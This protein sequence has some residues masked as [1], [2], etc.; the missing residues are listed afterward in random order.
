[1]AGSMNPSADPTLLGP[2]PGPGQLALFD[3]PDAPP[4]S[5]HEHFHHRDDEAYYRTHRDQGKPRFSLVPGI[6]VEQAAK[7]M[8]RGYE[9]YGGCTWK[10]TPDGAQRY[11]ESFLRHAMHV[12]EFGPLARDEETGMLHMAMAANDCGLAMWHLWKDGR[13][14]R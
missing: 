6:L 9:K 7:V 2:G 4:P 13:L 12:F 3:A 10:E 8:T 5:T 14:E 11:T 1:M